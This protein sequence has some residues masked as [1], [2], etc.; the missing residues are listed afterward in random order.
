MRVPGAHD[1]ARVDEMCEWPQREAGLGTR[2]KFHL[3]SRENKRAVALVSRQGPNTVWEKK[4]KGRCMS[5]EKC[6][7]RSDEAMVRLTSAS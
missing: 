5:Y 2:W 6:G 1:D 4:D 3:P 7:V